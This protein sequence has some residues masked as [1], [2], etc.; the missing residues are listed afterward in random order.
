M[1]RKIELIYEVVNH[2]LFGNNADEIIDEFE[3]Y[4]DEYS[5]TEWI[6]N[7]TKFHTFVIEKTPTA[8]TEYCLVNSLSSGGMSLVDVHFIEE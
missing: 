4:F 6:N 7:D 5:E 1:P 2:E 3:K 8:L